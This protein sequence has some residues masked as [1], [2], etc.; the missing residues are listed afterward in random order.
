[1]QLKL[2]KKEKNSKRNCDLIANKI[3]DKIIKA[4][5][6]LPHNNS[7]TVTNE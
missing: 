2:L 7:E 3:V 6:S 1:M 5:K 4:L